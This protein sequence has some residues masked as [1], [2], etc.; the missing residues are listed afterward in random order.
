MRATCYLFALLIFLCSCGTARKGFQATRPYPVADLQKDFTLFRDILE[1]NHP[2]LYWYNSKDSI[3]YFFDLGYS[4]INRPLTEPQFKLILSSVISNIRC[5]HTSVRSSKNYS[6]YL[7]TARISQFP[8]S[9]KFWK[10]TAAVY[11]NLNRR[12][13]LLVRG[14]RL[15]SING[16][17]INWYRDSIF[18]FLSMDG[19]SIDHKYQTISNRGGF[20]SWYR[21]IFGLTNPIRIVFTDTANLQRHSSIAPFNPMQDTIRPSVLIDYKKPERRSRRA[22][23][24]EADHSL[25]F[26]SSKKTA[27]LVINSFLRQN[28]LGHFIRKS[29]R[30]VHKKKVQNLIIDVRYNG[31][32]NVGLSNLLTK[33]LI[34]HRFKIADSLYANSRSF[35]NAK[36]IENQ[37]WYW[38]T[39]HFISRKKSDG[40]FHF[41]YFER[42]YFS[43]KKKN[44][45]AGNVYLLTGG[46][47]FSATTL[48]AKFIKGQK[49]VTLVGEETGGGAYGNTAW[50]IP[51]AT[52]PKTGL[53]FTVPRFRLVID[54]KAVKDGRGVMPDVYVGA[55]MKSIREGSDPKIERVLQLIQE[56]R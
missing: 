31:G 33:Y 38:L 6:R 45:F 11:A 4:R 19:F 28:N 52:L 42:H 12:D 43:P 55:S 30:T 32:G 41:G 10:D 37:F 5:G 49:N 20:S 24:A 26:D 23:R 16:K 53:R 27:Y 1:K 40:N 29:F 54:R 15:D 36:H 35:N 8:L 50:L 51:T 18:R 22:M 21:N 44:H 14:S 56:R 34:D 17:S 46:N 7:D 39:M 25:S 9:I 13:S 48:F 3:D 47:S 2:S